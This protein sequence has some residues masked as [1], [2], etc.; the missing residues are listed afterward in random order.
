[1]PRVL[2]ST[3]ARL[4]RAP[5]HSGSWYDAD[6]FILNS[7][8]SAWLA[9]ASSQ[10]ASARTTAQEA[11]GHVRAIIAPHAGYSYSGPTAAYAY[12][13]LAH[14]TDIKRVFLLGP[15]H[16][17]YL[18]DK[19][20]L[21]TADAY[22]TPLGNLDIDAD[23]YEQLKRTNQFETMD[24]DVDEAEHSLEM[25]CPYIVQ[26]TAASRNANAASSS[27]Y[28][29][30]VPVMVGSLGAHAEARY[31]ALFAPYLDDPSNVFVISS[32]FC[33][34]GS[35]FRYTPVPTGVADSKIYESIEVLDKRGMRLIEAQDTRG[36]QAYLAETGNTIC[37]RH[38]IGVLLNALDHASSKFGLHFT[39]YAQSGAVTSRGGSSVSYASA[40]VVAA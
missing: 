27:T 17:V 38:P 23:V 19:C 31:G 35:R 28:P 15:S 37:G 7:Q 12:E 29:T 34:W 6:P 5:T 9:D 32:D 11:H 16:H 40:L 4:Q 10:L 24:M 3:S 2:S 39:K 25:H 30:L 1:M 26:A 21:S 8:L 20:A 33:H 22:E 18:K 14:R 36:F 13:P